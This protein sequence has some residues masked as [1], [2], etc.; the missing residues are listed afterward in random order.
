MGEV[1]PEAVI[2][3]AAHFSHQWTAVVGIETDDRLDLPS[4]SIGVG[5]HCSVEHSGTAH[6][7]SHE[8]HRIK[9]Y[10]I[11]DRA[12]R[13]HALTSEDLVGCHKPG[14]PLEWAFLVESG[15]GNADKAVRTEV[16][17]DLLQKLLL[18]IEAMH[19]DHGRDLAL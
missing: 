15:V 13:S 4:Q 19:D 12:V 3:T 14:R 6:G 11:V 1:V 7:V 17:G 10:M 5:H 2:G 16:L 8:C 18:A 9:V